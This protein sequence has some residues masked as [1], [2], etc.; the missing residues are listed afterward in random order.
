MGFYFCDTS[1]INVKVMDT[2]KEGGL[3]LLSNQSLKIGFCR[4]SDIECFSQNQLI[5]I[6]EFSKIKQSTWDVLY[7]IKKPKRLN[8]VI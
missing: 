7:E 5:S 6:L 1:Q 4:H 3:Q 2:L 8:T